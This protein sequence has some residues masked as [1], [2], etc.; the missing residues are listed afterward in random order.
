MAV[1]KAPVIEKKQQVKEKQAIPKKLF[2]LVEELVGISETDRLQP[3]SATLLFIN[4]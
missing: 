2:W 1:K 4:L 3:I